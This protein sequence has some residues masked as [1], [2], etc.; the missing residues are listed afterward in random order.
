MGDEDVHRFQVAPSRLPRNTATLSPYLDLVARQN[1][2]DARVELTAKP[3]ERLTT[4]AAYHALWLDENADALYNAGGVP[5]RRRLSGNTSNE[6]GHELD[7]SA[8]L[9]IDVHSS[10]L[11]GWSHFWGDNF[12]TRTGPSEDADL[13]YFQYVYKF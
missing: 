9:K 5:V 6:L 13:L 10:V 12:V 2:F 1:I 8:S 4:R 11:L 7:L 3:T